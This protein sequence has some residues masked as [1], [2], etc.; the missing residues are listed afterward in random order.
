MTTNQVMNDREDLWK[1]VVRALKGGNAEGGGSESRPR[2]VRSNLRT[3]GPPMRGPSAKARKRYPGA[4]EWYSAP[5][6]LRKRKAVNLTL[7]PEALAELDRRAVLDGVSRSAV[8][9]RLVMGRR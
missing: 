7:S 2:A 4:P 9:E 1:L 6:A 3:H 5:S 8:V